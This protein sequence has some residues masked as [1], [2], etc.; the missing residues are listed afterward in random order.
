M[1]AGTLRDT[2]EMYI[3][4]IKKVVD[5]KVESGEVNQEDLEGAF[6]DIDTVRELLDDLT[7]N[8][9][10]KKYNDTLDSFSESLKA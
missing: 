8:K 5:E 9:D 1:N 4:G 3:D 10:I 2:I 7:S 6:Y